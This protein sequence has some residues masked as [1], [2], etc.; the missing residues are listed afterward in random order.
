[1]WRG[2][3]ASPR[4]RCGERVDVQ[5]GLCNVTALLHCASAH[6]LRMLPRLLPPPGLQATGRLPPPPPCSMCRLSEGASVLALQR[7]PQLQS[8][9]LSDVAGPTPAQLDDMLRR[10]GAVPP[11]G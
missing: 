10:C 2:C 6:A 7:L 8:L 9:E 3:R 1:M 11:S 4:C 5:C